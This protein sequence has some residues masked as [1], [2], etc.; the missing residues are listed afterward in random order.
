MHLETKWLPQTGRK[1]R[2]TKFNPK[3]CHKLE[4]CKDNMITSSHAI[5]YP[6]NSSHLQK[7]DLV[8]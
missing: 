6:A 5:D 8:L 1:Q 2:V 4:E 3:C 7:M